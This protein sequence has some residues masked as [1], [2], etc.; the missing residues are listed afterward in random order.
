MGDTW[1][2]NEKVATERKLLMIN[3]LPN[4]Q[5]MDELVPVPEWTYVRVRCRSLHA[6]LSQELRYRSFV[7]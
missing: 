6:Q 2:P 3:N 1:R 4:G 7:K 5:V